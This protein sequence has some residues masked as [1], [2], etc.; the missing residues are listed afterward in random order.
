L[1]KTGL[2]TSVLFE[3]EVHT[4]QLCKYCH[5][6]KKLIVASVARPFHKVSSMKTTKQNNTRQTYARLIVRILEKARCL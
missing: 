2:I 3:V 4:K 5:F 1:L 6:S